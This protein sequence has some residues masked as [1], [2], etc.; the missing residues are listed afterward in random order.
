M[1]IGKH[2]SVTFQRTLRVPDDGDTYPLPPTLGRLPVSLVDDYAAKVPKQWLEHHGVFVPMYQREALWIAFDGP[3]WRP[4]AVQVGV[5]MIN[6]LSGGTWAHQLC[7]DPQNYL[8]CPDQPWLDGIN[9]G[10]AVVRQF[11]AMPLGSETT[12]E[13]Q[14]TGQ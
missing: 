6:A 12:I 14:L 8:V 9:V 5:G 1:R 3:W 10:K 2:L 11:V 7:A 13:G 4:N